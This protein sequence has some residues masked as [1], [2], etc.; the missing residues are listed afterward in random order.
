MGMEDA[1]VLAQCLS[2]QDDLAASLAA[3]GARRW[4]RVSTILKASLAISAAQMRPD[5]QAEL[6]AANRAA[7]SA[8]AQPY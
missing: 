6:L 8:L 4:P 1:V 7:A 5:G 2:S 3:F